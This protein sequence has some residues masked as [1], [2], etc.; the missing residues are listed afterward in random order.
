MNID[1]ELA[2][3]LA[4]RRQ[5]SLYRQ[6]QVIS[7]AQAAHVSRGEQ[8]FLS[9]CSNDYLGLANDPRLAQALQTASARF[10]VGSGASHLVSGHS[11][12]HH[13]LEEEIAQ[14]TGRP[15][16]LLFSTGYMANLGVIS[17]LVGKGDTVIED[18]LNHA[19]LIDGGLQCGAEFTRYKHNDMQHLES[20][21]QA[22]AGRRKLIV[23]DGVFSMDGDLADL[24]AICALAKRYGAWVMVD[25][26]HGFGVLGEAGTGTLDHFGLGLDDVAIVVGTLGKAFGTFG[27]F[28]A[29]SETVIESLIQFARPYIYTTALPP[30]VAAATSASL[31]ILMEEDYRRDHLQTL[32]AHFRLKCEA[33]GLTLMPS[34]TPIQPVMVGD[35]SRAMAISAELESQGI[36]VT[37]IRPPTVPSGTSRLRVTLC[38]DHSL[39]DVNQLVSA[40][41]I[42]FDATRR[43]TKEV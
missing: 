26:A 5:Q 38:A 21:L 39:A 14:F 10:G 27:A 41:A 16:A 28:V 29:A 2:P 36:W 8:A 15:R 37:A 30:A 17:A 31:Q 7:S 32:I 19:S 34:T 33:S 35:E 13:L 42:A 9:F 20:R 43:E 18:K 25:D 11:E 4:E 3:A 23:V 6:R 1:D 22:S 40:L 12:E 24:P